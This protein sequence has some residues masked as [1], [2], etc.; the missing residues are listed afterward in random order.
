MMTL[1]F[2]W[3]W[4]ALANPAVTIDGD[5]LCPARADVAA[6]VA[7]LLPPGSTASKPDLV[8][9][10]SRDGA[11][12][13]RVVRPDG[14]PIGERVLVGAFPCADLA[15]AAA[16]IIATWESDVHPEFRQALPAT[17][18]SPV[19]PPPPAVLAATAEQPRTGSAFDVGAALFGSLAPGAGSSGAA[20]GA[21]VIA[22]VVPA[23]GR[24]GGR[25]SLQ[26]STQRELTLGNG[27]VRWRRL[28]GGVGPQLRLTSAGRA[29]TLDLHGDALVALV[30][31][32]GSGFA[33]NHSAGSVDAGIAAGARLFVG[34]RRSVQPWLDLSLAGWLRQEVAY[35]DPG[36]ASVKLPRVEG[37]L[38]LGLSF[39]S[40]P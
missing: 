1:G 7:D 10:D 26:G 27:A 34:P 15:A 23:G 31:A 39:C 30:S 14:A 32:S 25:L 4:L 19:T 38:A 17:R 16:V 29:A 36:G 5:S 20:V 40:Q 2:L 24:V 35:N 28:V 12:R 8:H 3:S 9:L 18:R 33:V 21:L 37:I 6:R 22:S 13:I 11:M